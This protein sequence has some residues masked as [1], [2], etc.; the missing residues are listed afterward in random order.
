MA[1]QRIKYICQQCGGAQ[2]KWMGRCPDCG[3]WNTLVETIVEEERPA[4]SCPRVSG[5]A[6]PQPL[7]A[8]ASDG[9]ERIPVPIGEL[10]RVLGGGIVPGSVVLLGGDPGIGKSTLLLELCSLLADDREVL[11]VSGEESAAQVKMRATRLGID[12]PRLYVLADTNLRSILA[13][14]ERMSPR[15]AVVDSIQ[16]IYTEELESAAGSV[17]QVRECAAQL[18]RLAKAQSIPIFLVGHVTKEG[19]IAGPRVLEHMVDTVLYLEGERFHTYRI[20][21]SVKNRFGSTNEVGVFEMVEQG[22]QEVSNPSEAFLAERLPNAAGSA[23][24]ITLEGT[25]PLLVEVQALTSVTSFPAPRRTG[26]GIDF[27]RLLL[28]VAVLSKRVGLRL[29]DQ[30]V[31]VN[32]VGGLTV[33]EPAA[34]LA[35]ACAIASSVRNIPVAADLAIVG[36][37]GLSGEL[38]SVSQ[39]ARRL[40]EASKLGFRRCLVPKSGLRHLSSSISG[41]EVIGARTLADALEIA[42]G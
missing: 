37:I 34:D 11:Y 25:R 35:I 7:P 22:L 4:I 13:Q 15:I 2:G 24:A 8:I 9:F 39:L 40:H 23:I 36:E 12:H 10:S 38:R 26:N 19:T 5:E 20:L 17:S 18:L 32:I 41:I 28:L 33:R 30:D 27:N 31:F 29:S 1:R 3:E 42:L 14:I 16:S 6:V 21:R